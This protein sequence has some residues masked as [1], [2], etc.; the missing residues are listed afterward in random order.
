[1]SILIHIPEAPEAVPAYHAGGE[2]PQ[3]DAA[4]HAA[5]DAVLR[6]EQDPL[7]QSLAYWEP[8]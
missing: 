4:H 6:R 1:M 5:R 7:W 3:L 8:A 2:P